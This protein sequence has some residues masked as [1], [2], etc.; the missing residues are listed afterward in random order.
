MQTKKTPHLLIMTGFWPTQENPIN[1]IF[2]VQQIDQLARLGIKITVIVEKTIGRLASSPLSVK[3]LNL[4]TA[5]IRLIEV[6]LFR[7]PE[8]LSGLPGGILLNTKLVGIFLRRALFKLTNTTEDF[9]GC[10][11]HVGRYMAL[12]IPTWKQRIA[13]KVLMVLHGVEPFLQVQS[14]INRARVFFEA[15]GNNADAVIL[16]GRPLAKYALTIGLPEKKIQI[17]PNGTVIPELDETLKCERLENIVCTIL[18][19]SNL[20]TL[21]GIDDNLHALAIT[22]KKRPDLNWVY[23][24]VGDGDERS[25]LE[26]LALE[27]GISDKV[28]FLGRISYKDTMREMEDANIFSLPSWNEAFGIVYLESMARMCPVIGCLDNGAAE[29]ITHESDGLLIPPRNITELANALERL[30]ENPELCLQLGI[31]GRKKAQQFSWERNAQ[32]MLS[33][34]NISIELVQ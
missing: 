20:V 14:N 33:L 3:E 12:S 26:D 1:G 25:R 24:I 34:M 23:R 7:L 2:V 6:P 30:I 9:D 10:I 22:S 27:L 19:V 11:V 8:K 4:S 29:I 28:L 5:N 17:V 31:N 21:K 16:V 13:G 15:T 18:S 32:S